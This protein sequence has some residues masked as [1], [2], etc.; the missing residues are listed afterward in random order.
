M[1]CVSFLCDSTLTCCV[2]LVPA[3][4]FCATR[5]SISKPHL[6][7]TENSPHSFTSHFYAVHASTGVQLV[8]SPC[9]CVSQAP[10]FQLLVA[11]H[12][13]IDPIS[14]PFPIRLGCFARGCSSSI[15]NI[16]WGA[17]GCHFLFLVQ[18]P[19]RAPNT[20]SATIIRL[21]LGISLPIN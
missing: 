9:F 11:T 3:D 5:S 8:V 18:E 17:A 4:I 10:H 6:F 19:I 16:I 15:S 14:P 12:E 7:L 13:Q 1:T 21:V 20:T 2:Q